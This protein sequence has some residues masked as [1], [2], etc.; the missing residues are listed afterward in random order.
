MS[1]DKPITAEEL[2]AKLRRDP[3]FVAREKSRAQEQALN[4]AR[5]EALAAP[6]LQDLDAI[7]VTPSSLDRLAHEYAPL[8]ADVVAV[9]MNWIPR[10][11]DRYLQESLIRPLGATGVSFNGKALI[12]AFENTGS[13][14]LRWAISN[15]IA[16][17]RP[18][19]VTDWLI[20][21]VQDPAYGNARQM[22]CLA[23][24][25]LASEQTANDV[26]ISIF[27]QLP[28]HV[29][30]A[31]AESGGRRELKL[32][33]EMRTKYKGWIRKE[34]DKAVRAIAKRLGPN[35]LEVTD[36]VS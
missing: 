12:E 22:L 27:D 1:K 20:G 3:E 18:T 26:L 5:F 19:G 35:I 30:L 21:V 31:L 15:T 25:R 8:S 36:S 13:E 4:V 23:V 16:E 14:G 34:I 6:I 10:T 7:G 33:R 2:M 17:A 28:G 24:A 32:L 9:L 29:A 11:T